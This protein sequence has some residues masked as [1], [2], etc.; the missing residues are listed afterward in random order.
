[1]RQPKTPD[2]ANALTV[3]TPS[4]DLVS[5]EALLDRAGEYARKS[6]SARTVAQYRKCCDKYQDW[7]T[8]RGLR[9]VP[10]TIPAVCAYVAWLAGGQDNGKPYA[11]S[12]IEQAAAAIKYAHGLARMKPHYDLGQ[13]RDEHGDP[14]DWKD[15]RLNAAMKGIR[16]D[17]AE[18]RQIKRA[19]ALTDQDMRE[20]LDLLRPEMPREARDAAILVGLY[21]GCRRRSE[22]AGLDYQTR[23]VD[24]KKRG[25]GV[26]EIGPDGLVI[27]LYK[28]KTR[29][30]GGEPERYPINRKNAPRACAAV[31]AWIKIGGI[32]PGTPVF[33]GILGTGTATHQQV[34]HRGV[35]WRKD[36]QKWSAAYQTGRVRR[37]LGDFHTAQ[38]AI[39]A[40]LAAGGHNSPVQPNRIHEA[41][42][43]CVVQNVMYEVLCKRALDES[44]RKRLK[45]EEKA[46]LWKLA[47]QYSGHSGRSGSIT[48]AFDRNVPRHDVRKMSGH[49]EGSAQLDRYAQG[50]EGKANKFLVGS[51]L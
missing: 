11:I 28:S 23:V 39:A 42:L 46:A 51:G 2:P 32:L 31:E 12:S 43:A 3:L 45:P 15:P 10:S 17:L 5:F 22:V 29:Q 7:C 38:E 4:R 34:N 9:A 36:R 6:R 14:G 30:D 19:K 24:P 13:P 35:R 49:K 37:W 1:M 47:R 33:R 50:A 18:Q 8:A 48:S 26:L 25:T 40:Y 21:A 20:I 41:S 44:G 27:I 16:R